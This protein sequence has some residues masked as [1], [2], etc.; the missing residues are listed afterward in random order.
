METLEEAIETYVPRSNMDLDWGDTRLSTNDRALIILGILLDNPVIEE[1]DAH[2]KENIWEL[3][4]EIY[5]LLGKRDDLEE[6]VMIL[7][8][9]IKELYIEHKT[10]TQRLQTTYGS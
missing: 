6:E 4:K 10:E 1:T 2:I 8:Q 7:N 9:T 5:K 3:D